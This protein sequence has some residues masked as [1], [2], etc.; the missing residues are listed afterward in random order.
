[1]AT[2][3]QQHY[4]DNS[5][6]V[7]APPGSAERMQAVDETTADMFPN[8]VYLPQGGPISEALATHSSRG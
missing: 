6:H 8:W 5:I 4:I 1:M 3:F 2:P 7:S